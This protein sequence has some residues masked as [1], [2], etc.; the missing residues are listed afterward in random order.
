MKRRIFGNVFE[1]YLHIL[2]I[3]DA[4]FWNILDYLTPTLT[5]TVIVQMSLRQICFSAC[6]KTSP[7]NV[8]SVEEIDKN[9]TNLTWSQNP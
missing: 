7:L 1:T 3:Y 9:W 2:A 6:W 8:A 4:M 5:Q